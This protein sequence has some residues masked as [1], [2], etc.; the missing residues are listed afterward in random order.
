MKHPLDVARS[1]LIA[2]FPACVRLGFPIIFEHR[3]N[4]SAWN[5]LC[6]FDI[7][8]NRS[9]PIQLFEFPFY[10]I[11]TFLFGEFI[12]DLCKNQQYIYEYLLI[13]RGL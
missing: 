6:F 3:L 12:R 13:F 9:H 5:I 10:S 7:W 11:I 4:S 2:P 8:D 1:D